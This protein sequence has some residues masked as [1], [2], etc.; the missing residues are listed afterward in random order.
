MEIETLQARI[1]KIAAYNL[2]R[3][4]HSLSQTISNNSLL[5]ANYIGFPQ[6]KI[7]GVEKEIS[8]IELL[9]V[10]HY[11]SLPYDDKFKIHGSYAKTLYDYWLQ[12]YIK[13]EIDRLV[14]MTEEWQEALRIK[15][16]DEV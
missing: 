10:I 5:R 11:P 3:D 16:E 9:E 8:I 7:K 2:K 6:L 15:E 13:R 12:T 14:Q 1:E 4:L